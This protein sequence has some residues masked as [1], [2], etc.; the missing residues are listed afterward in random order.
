MDSSGNA[1]ESA[2]LR[3][4]LQTLQGRLRSV[5]VGRRILMELLAQQ[6]EETR[7]LSET[8]RAVKRNQRRSTLRCLRLEAQLKRPQ[9]PRSTS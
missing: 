3:R 6:M 2:C 9:V 8:L 7:R 4:R 1:D 5:R